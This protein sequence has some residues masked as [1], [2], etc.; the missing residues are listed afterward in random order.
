MTYDFV[1][2]GSGISGL[3]SAVLLGKAGY[4]VVVVEQHN[5]LGGCMQVFVRDKTVFDTG[6]HYVGSLG[7]DELLNKLFSYLGI[8]NELT[9]E[10]MAENGFDTVLLEGDNREYKYP[11]GFERFMKQIQ[12]YFPD[13]SK[14]VEIFVNKMK[15]IN[16]NFPLHNLSNFS[17]TDIKP[18]HISMSVGAYLDSLTENEKL[19]NVLTG[20]NYLYGGKKYKTPL[21]VHALCVGSY[22]QS[23]WRFVGGSSQVTAALRKKLHDYGGTFVKKFKV[24][25]LGSNDGKQIHFAEN[26]NGER[27]KGHHFIS[28][29]HPAI[30]SKLTDKGLLRDAYKKRLNNIEN[31]MS[32]FCLYIK[33]KPK[34]FAYR[35]SNYYYLKNGY[36]WAN[37]NYKESDWPM[38]FYFL[39]PPETTNS[40]Y[41]KTAHLMCYM[42]YHDVEQWAGSL[43]GERPAEYYELMKHKAKRLLYL[44]D[45]RFPGLIDSIEKYYISSPLTYHDYLGT[46]KGSIYGLM[47]DSNN[48]LRTFVSH[49][50]KVPNLWLA[51]QSILLN[52]MIGSAMSAVITCGEILGLEELINNIKQA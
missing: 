28:T 41:A 24:V 45:E 23:S 49:K 14:T 30:T 42:R 7:K 39:T 6:I 17:T 22:I 35:N 52:G 12:S 46:P 8:M 19:K 31:T 47:K 43:T 40:A 21:Y 51:G 32:T 20:T 27:I 1:I 15:E 16:E 18:E 2:I 13:E 11:M 29:L 4:K 37:E 3:V 38:N 5:V 50:T 44:A 36:E 10:R 26:Q 25:R 9:V 34:T 48:V 33:F